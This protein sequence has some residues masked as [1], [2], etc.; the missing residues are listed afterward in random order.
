MHAVLNTVYDLHVPMLSVESKGGAHRIFH[1]LFNA[2]HGSNDFSPDIF[3]VWEVE[4][5]IY[6]K[7]TYRFYA[8]LLFIS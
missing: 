7:Q 4:A 8:L 5:P 6:L 3:T 1:H 2:T